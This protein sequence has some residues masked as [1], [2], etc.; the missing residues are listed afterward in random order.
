MFSV[1]MENVDFFHSLSR[2]GKNG[3]SLLLVAET[4]LRTH[5][6]SR[7]DSRLWNFTPNRFIFRLSRLCRVQ[8]ISFIFTYVR[9][10]KFQFFPHCVCL[11]M[12]GLKYS[13]NKIILYFYGIWVDFLSLTVKIRHQT[14]RIRCFCIRV[15]DFV[16][17]VA[18]VKERREEKKT[19]C[20]QWRH[21]DLQSVRYTHQLI[22]NNILIWARASLLAKLVRLGNS[23]ALFSFIPFSAKRLTIPRKWNAIYYAF[24]F[25]FSFSCFTRLAAF[26]IIKNVDFFPLSDSCQN[27]WSAR[28]VV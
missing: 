17:T 12:E 14:T 4:N 27:A 15:R 1:S 3:K 10:S 2:S 20:I 8:Q 26:F 16:C 23:F 13:T 11:H 19:F 28:Q 25:A 21:T 6:K 7:T 9:Q 22:H 24:R 5:K 18:K